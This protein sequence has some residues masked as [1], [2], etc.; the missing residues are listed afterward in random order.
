MNLQNI[1]VPFLVVYAPVLLLVV[2][3]AVFGCL[4][5]ARTCASR[6]QKLGLYCI[7]VVLMVLQVLLSID[8]IHGLWQVTAASVVFGIALGIII[9]FQWPRSF[10][11]LFKLPTK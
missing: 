6:W 4:A 3:V 2:C 10:G 1:P 5:A 9:F 11:F 7:P 8:A